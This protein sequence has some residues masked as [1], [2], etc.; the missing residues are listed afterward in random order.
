MVSEHGRNILGLHESADNEVTT[1]TWDENG[2]SNHIIDRTYVAD[3]V[4]WIVDYKTGRH[5]G[6][7]T[8]T[9]LESETERY[10]PQ[11]RRYRDA[12]ARVDDRPIRTALYFP[13]LDVFHEVDCDVSD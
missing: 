1:T 12:L 10:R 5:Q 13:L 2:F 11:L 8:Q 9:F 6:G 4:R 7:D 3:G